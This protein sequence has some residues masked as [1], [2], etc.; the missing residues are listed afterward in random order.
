ML[1]QNLLRIALPFVISL[2]CTY[3][4]GLTVLYAIADFPL[5]FI[6]FPLFLMGMAIAFGCAVLIPRG[7]IRALRWGGAFGAVG[8]AMPL[9]ANSLGF[10]LIALLPLFWTYAYL[11]GPAAKYGAKCRTRSDQS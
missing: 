3:W 4:M 9:I 11:Q 6:V 1:L 7:C 5:L 10:A 2:L 8:L